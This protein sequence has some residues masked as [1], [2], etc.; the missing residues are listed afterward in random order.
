MNVLRFGT[1]NT[2][3]FRAVFGQGF[4]S[5]MEKNGVPREA[6]A[7]AGGVRQDGAGHVQR[8]F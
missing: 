8:A 6:I 7:H 4:F 2:E 5:F 3:S 1:V